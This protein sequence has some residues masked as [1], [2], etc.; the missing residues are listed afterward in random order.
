MISYRIVQ[1]YT[2][3]NNNVQ[4]NKTEKKQNAISKK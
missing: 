4:Q 1:Q 2:M 3:K